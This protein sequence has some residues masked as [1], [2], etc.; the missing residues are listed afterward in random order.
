MTDAP[1]DPESGEG[2][3]EGPSGPTFWVGMVL[4]GLLV[5][6]GLRLAMA[7][8]ANWLNSMT[9]WFVAGGVLVDLAVVPVVAL[10]GLAGRRVLPDWAWRVVRAA[11][12]VTALLVV[13]SLVLLGDPGGKPGNPTVRSRDFGN[14]LMVYLIVVWVLALVGLA[15]SWY[16]HRREIATV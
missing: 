3:L 8:K 10:V 9:G 11:L 16:A 12:L 15:A 5:A 7:S 6:N 4:G 14:G 1:D 13:Y 2:H